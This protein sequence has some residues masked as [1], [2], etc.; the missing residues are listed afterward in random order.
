M[1]TTIIFDLSEV[2]L[3]GMQGIEETISQE[4]NSFIPKDFIHTQREAEEFF[5][6]RITENEFWQSLVEK[7]KWNIS[8]ERLKSMVR[9]QMTE[10]EGTREILESLKEKGF[11]MGLLSIHGKEWVDHLEQ[12]FDYHKLFHSRTYSF[13]VGVGKPDPRAFELIIEKLK[14]EPFECLFVDDYEVNVHAARELGIQGIIFENAEQL[15]KDLSLLG[16]ELT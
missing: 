4:S 1:I 15:E 10:I 13:E 8:V 3:R 16:I 11:K 9:D 2:Y 12:K 6:G 5:N 7:N 14:V